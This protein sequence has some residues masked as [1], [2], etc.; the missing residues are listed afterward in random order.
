MLRAREK[1]RAP[2]A[3]DAH[4][5]DRSK[6]RDFANWLKHDIAPVL[7]V[8]GLQDENCAVAAVV[9]AQDPKVLILQRAGQLRVDRQSLKR[10]DFRD[11]LPVDV[12]FVSRGLDHDELIIVLT[13]VLGSEAEARIA[14]YDVNAGFIFK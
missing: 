7:V 14:R 12:H 3:H 13:N 5:C 4:R 2:C 8:P 10:V 11:A 6:G 9:A 1:V